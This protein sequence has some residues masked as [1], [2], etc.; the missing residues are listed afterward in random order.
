MTR[1]FVTP[2]TS[3][4][5]LFIVV[6][7]VMMFFNFG[8]SFV[9]SAHEWLGLVFGAVAI[10]HLWRH[11]KGFAAY[12]RRPHPRAVLAGVAMISLV[13]VALTAHPERAGV[14]PRVVFQSLEAAPLAAVA[15][16]AGIDEA[17]LRLAL[18]GKGVD[19]GSAHSLREVAQATGA[20]PSLLVATLFEHR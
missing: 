6:S 20:D 15:Q 12:L 18:A 8:E 1:D 14:S 9:K 5:F 7:G 16:V 3:I 19:V 2:A 10:W 4:L 11:F 13:V 17:G